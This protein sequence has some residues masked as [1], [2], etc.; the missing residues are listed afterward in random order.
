MKV[1]VAPPNNVFMKNIANPRTV[2]AIMRTTIAVIESSKA[3]FVFICPLLNTRRYLYLNT[4]GLFNSYSDSII[5]TYFLIVKMDPINVL[6]WQQDV[7]QSVRQIKLLESQRLG[8]FSWVDIA[9]QLEI[10]SARI[11]GGNTEV[12]SRKKELI[13]YDL[14]KAEVRI[15]T[16][17]V[18]EAADYVKDDRMAKKK[19]METS[20]YLHAVSQAIDVHNALINMQEQGKKASEEQIAKLED[21]IFRQFEPYKVQFL[22]NLEA[23][24]MLPAQNPSSEKMMALAHAVRGWTVQP[25]D[26]DML[27]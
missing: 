15:L 8:G 18:D 19:I 6:K 17:I 21:A 1:D 27:R 13:N 25:I 16:T 4:F 14:L 20:A 9:K 10:L 23:T 7:R 5:Y 3:A 12:I 11:S 26:V 22:Q 24:S 2:M